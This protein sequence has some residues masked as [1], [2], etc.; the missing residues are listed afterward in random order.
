[1]VILKNQ[2]I[3][4][5]INPLGA[6]LQELTHIE[7]GNILWKKDDTIW[8]RYAPILFPIVSGLCPR[9]RYFDHSISE[10]AMVIEG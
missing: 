1:M 3:R 6:E 5:M 4:M 2:H 9:R 10:V 8:N 7:Y